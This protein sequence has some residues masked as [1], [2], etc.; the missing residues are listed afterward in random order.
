M[1]DF[2][3]KMKQDFSTQ[4]PDILDKIKRDAR[5]AIP[6]KEVKPSIL[7]LF[8]SRGIRYSFVSLFVIAILG[9]M[10]LTTGTENQVYAATV[11]MEINPQIEILIDEDDLV[12]EVNLLSDDG[13]EIISNDI[14]L[15]GKT[16]DEVLEYLIKRLVEEDYISSTDDNVLMFYVNGETIEIQE[17]VLLRVEAKLNAEAEKYNRVINYLNANNIELTDQQ[18]RRVQRIITDYDINPGRAAI[19]IKIIAESDAYTIEDLAPMKMRNLEQI[20]RNI[21]NQSQNENSNQRNGN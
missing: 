13:T 10:F 7:D 5:F 3:T 4:T 8:R 15:K 1:E 16:L 9:V 12:M 17:R 14:S 6:E 18:I 19:I 2:K 20:Y 21:V 11:T